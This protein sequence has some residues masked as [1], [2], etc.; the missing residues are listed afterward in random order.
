MSF[1]VCEL[2]VPVQYKD[3]TSWRRNQV[4]GAESFACRARAA[5]KWIAWKVEAPA[6]NGAPGASVRKFIV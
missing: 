6:R 3:N 4:V 2:G 5:G 1:L